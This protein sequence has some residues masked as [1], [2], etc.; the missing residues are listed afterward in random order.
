MLEKSARTSSSDGSRKTREWAR[1]IIQARKR[2]VDKWLG[3][4][5]SGR[6][7]RSCHF[8]DRSIQIGVPGWLSW[9]GSFGSAHDP[10]VL[11][12]NP[13]SGFLLGWEPA[14]PSASAPAPPLL[15]SLAVSVCSPIEHF[16]LVQPSDLK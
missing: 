10:R 14:S 3:L 6:A 9:L 8:V 4:D 2:G 15:C 7:R 12:S 16:H 1:A 5:T 11:E 13:V